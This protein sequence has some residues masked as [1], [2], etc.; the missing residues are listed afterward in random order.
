MQALGP[1]VGGAI[2]YFGAD[3]RWTE[4]VSLTELSNA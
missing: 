4:Y 2:V 3:W 1:V